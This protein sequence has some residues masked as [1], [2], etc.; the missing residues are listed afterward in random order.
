[1]RG[2]LDVRE[3]EDVGDSTLSFNEVKALAS[4]NPLLLDKAKADAEL[5]RLDR[6]E[7]SHTTGLSRLRHSIENHHTT[8]DRVRAEASVLTAAI[9]ARRDTRGEKFAMTVDGL[10]FTERADAGHAL[11]AWLQA[12]LNRPGPSSLTLP[13]VVSLGGHTFDATLRRD[14]TYTGY[15]LSVTGIPAAVAT[16]TATALAEAGLTSLP[17]RLE[18]VLT[19]LDRLLAEAHTTITASEQEIARAETQLQQPFGY[20]DDLEHAR[21]TCADLDQAIAALAAPEAGQSTTA[22]EAHQPGADPGLDAQEPHP[23]IAALTTLTPLPPGVTGAVA[24]EDLDLTRGGAT[25]IHHLGGPTT[26]GGLHV[27]PGVIVGPGPW[28]F[29]P[30]PDADE[31]LP[32]TEPDLVAHESH[33]ATE[34]AAT[35]PHP[36]MAALTTLAPP[37]DRASTP[38]AADTQV[39]ARVTVPTT[40]RG[41]SPPQRSR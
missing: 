24:P 30:D 40:A 31:H 27:G 33:P 18:N 10:R 34:S 35:E 20:A 25:A 11:R 9:A 1:M 2:T 29:Y 8:L 23:A 26:P 38:A 21:R 12:G 6:L 39:T 32:D 16:G 37:P 41:P 15:E 22:P 13:A 3:I 5:T 4:G 14:R 19:R 36:A 17:I 7:R 28:D